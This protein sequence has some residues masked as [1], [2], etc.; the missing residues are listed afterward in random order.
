VVVC[1]ALVLLTAS[2]RD[3]YFQLLPAWPVFRHVELLRLAQVVEA[4]LYKPG[5]RESDSLLTSSFR[6]HYGYGVT[7]SLIEMSTRGFLW[8]VEA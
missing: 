6:P 8:G 1:F 4:L 3:K 7:Q 5:G 2:C